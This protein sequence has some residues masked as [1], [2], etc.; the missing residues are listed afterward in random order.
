MLNVLKAYKPRYQNE[1]MAIQAAA[2]LN[3]LNW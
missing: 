2:P 3:E 1:V